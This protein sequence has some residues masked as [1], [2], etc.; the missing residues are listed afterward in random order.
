MASSG[1]GISRRLKLIAA[2]GT[3]SFGVLSFGGCGGAAVEE[4]P[5][6]AISSTAFGPDEPIP[7]EF[8]CDGADRSPPLRWSDPPDGTRSF[9]LIVED[10]DA[11]GGT[12]RHWGVYDLPGDLRELPADAGSPQAA[13][14]PQARNDFGRPGYGGPCPPRGHGA[15]RYLFR[16]LALDVAHLEAGATPTV[17][18]ILERA[19]PHVL[20]GGVLT[21]RYGRR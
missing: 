17:D 1:S 2:I 12:F 14:F 6:M 19:K 3:L 7:V 21:G 8:T 15:H 20:A 5:P 4:K 18:K 9:A 16:L 10:P 11:P 13:Q